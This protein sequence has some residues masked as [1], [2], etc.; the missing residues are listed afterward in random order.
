VGGYQENQAQ[1]APDDQIAK[2]GVVTSVDISSLEGCP[3][4]LDGL[5]SYVQEK[6]I[7]SM[8]KLHVSQ[9]ETENDHPV[10]QI[11]FGGFDGGMEVGAK[12]QKY[13]DAVMASYRTVAQSLQDAADGTRRIIDKY[14]TAEQ[15][16][17][18]SA[19]DIERVLEA[20]GGAGGTSTGTGTTTTASSSTTTAS[21]STS[22]DQAY[23]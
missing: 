3:P 22:T 21:S 15:R 14:K 16:N 7:P 20:G 11:I 10:N 18:T 13:Y 2:Q 12:H 17:H 4:W 5:K 19:L 9:T 6:L 1:S 8:S 23:N